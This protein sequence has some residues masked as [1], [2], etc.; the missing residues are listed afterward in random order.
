MWSES[1]DC[2]EPRVKLNSNLRQWIKFHDESVNLR[3]R[4]LIWIL[5]LKFVNLYFFFQNNAWKIHNE[6]FLR[7]YHKNRIDTS[8]EMTNSDNDHTPI[9]CL[10]SQTLFFISNIIFKGIFSSKVDNSKSF[11]VENTSNIRGKN[12][13]KRP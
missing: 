7:I 5:L 1:I 10:I 9:K 6:Q 11:S 12:V 13:T 3:Q 4:Y 2:G 8:Q